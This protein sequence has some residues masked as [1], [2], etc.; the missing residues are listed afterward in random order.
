[1]GQTPETDI[2]NGSGSGGWGEKLRTNAIS[3]NLLNV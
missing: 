3:F 1:M 2:E